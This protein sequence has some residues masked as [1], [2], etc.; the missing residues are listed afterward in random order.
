LY[1]LVSTRATSRDEQDEP[2]ETFV[3]LLVLSP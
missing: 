2:I 1:F 3:V